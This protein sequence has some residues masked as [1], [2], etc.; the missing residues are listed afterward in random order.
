MERKNLVCFIA[1]NRCPHVGQSYIILV[2]FFISDNLIHLMND[3]LTA[4][5]GK[6]FHTEKELLQLSALGNEEA[7][8]QLFHLVRHKLFGF[9]LRLTGSPE[10]AQD[11]VQDVFLKLWK[12]R[13]HLNQIENFS[14]YI[15]RVIQNQAINAI[16]RMANENLIR[17]KIKG[18]M[19]ESYTLTQETMEYR[20]LQTQLE[21][22]LK[23]LPPQQ[24]LIFKLSREGGLKHG[25]IA[26][27]LNISPST[28]K[29]HLVAALHTIRRSL[30]NILQ[31][32]GQ[33]ILIAL[34]YFF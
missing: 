34:A 1:V 21:E 2:N 16:K 28:V 19:N 13:I 7:F 17:A 4:L 24:R 33:F 11:L 12:E 15:F 20:E 5:P 32:R 18:G 9:A 27:K 22:I 30:R 29:N 23:K 31:V 8:T 10:L 3:Y 6:Y 26:Q 14:A 25:E